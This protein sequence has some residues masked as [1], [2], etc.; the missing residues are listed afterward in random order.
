MEGLVGEPKKKCVSIKEVD[1]VV[2]DTLLG[3]V[4]EVPSVLGGVFH[5]L[6]SGG[7][8]YME[9][10]TWN[11]SSR[12]KSIPLKAQFLASTFMNS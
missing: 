6:K 5:K 11:G 7:A 12:R 4:S 8:K 2:E 3:S 1:L 10:E 9:L